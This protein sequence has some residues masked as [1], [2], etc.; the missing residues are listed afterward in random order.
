M[1]DEPETLLDTLRRL[2]C[3]GKITPNAARRIAGMAVIPDD[4]GLCASCT[5]ER[6]GSYRCLGTAHP[7]CRLHTRLPAN[8]V[9]VT[10]SVHV[11][12]P[13]RPSK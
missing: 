12:R 9:T 5:P 7:D 4:G 2:I 1:M 8:D 10:V 3:E 13:G 6:D 11:E